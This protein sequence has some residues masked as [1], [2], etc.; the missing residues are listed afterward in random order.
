MYGEGV[1]DRP[2]VR[3]VEWARVAHQQ[4]WEKTAN[5]EWGTIKKARRMRATQ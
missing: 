4:R 3:S 5:A 2:G 1:A